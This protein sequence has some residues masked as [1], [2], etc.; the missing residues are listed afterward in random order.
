MPYS[1]ERRA[2]ERKPLT[3]NQWYVTIV[4]GMASYIDAS[5]IVSTGLA[6][7]MF[8]SALNLSTSEV[9]AFSSAL[10]A[11]IAVGAVIGGR[12]GDRFGR[13]PVFTVT[14]SL[15]I[16]ACILL[17]VASSYF[18]LLAGAILLGFA[19]GADLPVSISTI[20]ETA[21]K[22]Q[23]GATISFSQFLWKLGQ[24]VPQ[25]LGAVVGDWGISGGRIM[26]AQIGFVAF[27][28]MFLRLTIPETKRWLM[29][30][31]ALELGQKQV[32]TNQRLQMLFKKPYLAPFIALMGFY[33]LINM[34]LNTNGQYGTY[35]FTQVAGTTISTYSKLSL[36]AT[37]LGFVLVLLLMRVID[38][39]H[40]MRWFLFGA[41][42]MLIATL[43]P[44]IIGINATALTFWLIGMAIFSVFAGEPM[45]KVWTQE[46]FPTLLRS[47][48]QGT[49]IAIARFF[50]AILALVT[51]YVLSI[52][53][54]GLFIFLFVVM[55]TGVGVAYAVFRNRS[56]TAFDEEDADLSLQALSN[57]INSA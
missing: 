13:R 17:G 40:R 38:G 26:Y 3:H 27:I 18:A 6:I 1:K 35:M 15:I 53:P 20:S 29:S 50:A 46:S 33:T 7:I 11:A 31:A 21:K 19:T 47:T 45:M 25:A 9:G 24:I 14:M 43:T 30:K 54:R 56:K 32:T 41:F 22:T 23:R 28:T 2:K 8:K 49:I 42:A 34:G 37:I 10:T 57:S 52:G 12:L 51:P 39:K 44:I 36:V 48:A 4:A 16:I 5:A 55:T